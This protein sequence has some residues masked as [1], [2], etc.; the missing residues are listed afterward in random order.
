M[1]KKKKIKSKNLQ[2]KSTFLEHFHELRGRLLASFFCL[3]IAS[4]ASYFFYQKILFVL[5]LPLNQS[6]YYLSPTGGL[7]FAIKI[8]FF[9]GLFVSMPFVIYQI[10]RFL[11]PAFPPRFI[12]SLFIFVFISMFLFYLGVI[13]AYFVSLPASLYFL[14]NFESENIKALISTDDYLTFVLSFLF[15]FGILF[16]LPLIVVIVNLIYPLSIKILLKFQ[17]YLFVIAFVSSAIITPTPDFFN[18]MIMALPIILLYQLSILIVF[19]FNK[20]D[21]QK[22]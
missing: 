15:G 20:F 12:H 18:Q 3:L 13:F 1:E 11:L 4:I 6:L 8:S 22:K 9:T 21:A 19:I 2:N 10:F 5:L 14:S 7:N 16:Q 17:K